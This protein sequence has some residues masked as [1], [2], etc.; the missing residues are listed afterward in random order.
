ML[1]SRPRE[2]HGGIFA[3]RWHLQSESES[4]TLEDLC[5]AFHISPTKLKTDFKRF[6]GMPVMAYRNRIRLEKARVMLTTTPMPQ[7]QVA[8]ACGFAD[9]SYFIRAFKKHYGITPAVCRKGAE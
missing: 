9:E 4:P 1:S 7:A 3:F 8:Y 5:Q 6:T 2:A